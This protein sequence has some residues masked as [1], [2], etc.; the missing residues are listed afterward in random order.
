[1]VEKSID[2]AAKKALQET[3]NIGRGIKTLE[4]KFQAFGGLR[5][6]NIRPFTIEDRQI[7]GA[8]TG[9]QAKL[10]QTEQAVNKTA[11]QMPKL[12]QGTNQATVALTNFGRVVQDAP[13]GIIGI[14]NNID[15]LIQS[16]TALRAST[17]STSAAFSALGSSLLGPAGIAIA[18][19]TLSSLAILYTQNQQKQNAAVKESVSLFEQAAGEVSKNVVQVNALVLALKSGELS[20][21][22]QRKAQNELIKISPQ[23]KEAFS[24]SAVDV[25]KL[26]AALQKFNQT[27]INNL[28]LS[29]ATAILTKEFEKLAAELVSKKSI[30]ELF[31]N[32]SKLDQIPAF[33]K[34]REKFKASLKDTEVDFNSFDKRVQ[35]VFKILGV[36]YTTFVESFKD[37]APFKPVESSINNIKNSLVDSSL[38]ASKLVLQF[39]ELQQRGL[40]INDAVPNFDKLIAKQKEFIASGLPEKANRTNTILLTPEQ[41]SKQIEFYDLLAKKQAEIALINQQLLVPLSQSLVSAF[42]E[43]FSSIGTDGENAMKKFGKAIEE[44]TKRILIQ[45]AVTQ[46]LKALLNSIAPGTGSV[47]DSG[48]S[49]FGTLRGNDINLTILRG[50]GG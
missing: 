30:D 23:F 9:I 13:F 4:E 2:L 39:T 11:A 49:I 21:E 50:L 1:R 48:G 35:E 25:G 42:T 44:T 17:G 34:L 45:F 7:L 40:T 12:G 36:N 16:F 41:I 20:L 27:I 31:P 26:D 28:K 18:V 32:L 33:Q 14:A 6:F 43:L 15:P 22:N 24:G 37:P 29:A 46:A 47:L 5:P 10:R 8:L 3:S 38:A 19:S